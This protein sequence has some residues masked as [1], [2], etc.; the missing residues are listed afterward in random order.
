MKF[1]KETERMGLAA[2]LLQK[3]QEDPDDQ[4]LV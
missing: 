1:L 4:W 3:I 2:L